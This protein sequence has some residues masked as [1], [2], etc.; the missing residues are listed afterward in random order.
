VQSRDSAVPASGFDTA[1][2]IGLGTQLRRDIKDTVL[3]LEDV[4]VSDLMKLLRE[5]N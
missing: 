1:G 3:S 4:Q 2:I 5:L